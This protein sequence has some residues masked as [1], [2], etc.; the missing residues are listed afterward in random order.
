MKRALVISSFVSSSAVGAN[1]SAF[2]LRRLGIEAVVLPT[3]LLGRHPGWG[4]PGGQ[5]TP[6]DILS[7]MW[8]G[9]AAQNLRF[10][11]VLTGYMGSAE[12]AKITQTIIQLIKA[13]NPDC[14]IIVDP[15]MGDNGRLYVSE[16]VAEAI[17][18]VL[19][20]LADYITP[21]SWELSYLMKTDVRSFA[22]T[23][24]ALSGFE[25]R[26]L[27]TSVK[28][29][30]SIGGLLSQSGDITFV[31]HDKFD[32]IPHG[33]GD[34]LAGL[35]L[36]HMLRGESAETA[37]QKSISSIFQIMKFAV[38][39]DCAELPIVECQDYLLDAPLLDLVKT[40]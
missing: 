22:D 33:G 7:D 5:L 8:T 34:A 6:D 29:D 1:V 28:L 25:G 3:T 14:Q 4:D 18:Q 39:N 16:N 17:A 2:A 36:A 21:N 19:V 15:V 24:R 35:F 32:N 26:A 9:I 30:S 20:P 31:S 23:A 40:A 10:D 38:E 12:N 13:E 11:A 27:V 37:A